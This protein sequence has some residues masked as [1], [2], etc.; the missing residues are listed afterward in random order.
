M[1]C[2]VRRPAVASVTLVVAAA[3]AAG[4]CGSAGHPAAVGCLSKGVQSAAPEATAG[5]AADWT[6]PGGDLA[7]TRDVASAI[8]SS[9]VAQL[10]VAWCVPVESTGATKA[11]GIAEW[12]RDDAGR[13][14]WRGLHPGSR[15]ER[16]GDQARHRPGLVDA[17][18][19]LAERRPGRRQCRRRN[20]VC[21]DGQRR[22]RPVGGHRQAAVEP[23]PDRQRPG[24]HRHGARLQRRHRVRLDRARQPEQGRVPGRRQGHPVGAE[25]RHRRAGMVLGRGAEPVGEPGPQLR[26]RPV[27]SAVVRQPGQPLHRHREPRPDRAGRLAQGLP[28]GDQPA[29]PGPVHRLGRQAQ[30][31]PASCCG[32]TSSPRTTCSTGTC[33]TR[34]CSPPPTG[35]RWSSTAARPAS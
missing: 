10:G 3:L 9:N 22:G 26:R 17:H 18:L 21:G 19:Q 4:G 24:G 1:R 2:F 5:A 16:D 29:R 12:L 14:Q 34:P 27:G 28:V 13:G 11:A 33:R 25:R 31:A 35:S 7:N 8:T 15:V 32:T 20:R 6:L 23:D 30:P